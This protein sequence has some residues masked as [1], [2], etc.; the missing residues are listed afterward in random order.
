MPL[1][2]RRAPCADK[3]SQQASDPFFR[4]RKL[5]LN[6]TDGSSCDN[7]YEKRDDDDDDDEDADDDDDDDD[8][9]TRKKSTL[10][11][12]LC[13]RDA[14]TSQPIVSFVGSMD[15]CTYY[16]EIRTSAACGGIVRGPSGDGLGP[17]GVFGVM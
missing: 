6:Y 12:F 4:G 14:L 1:G 5:V 2:G 10:I 17:G 3:N 8:D 7:D 13:D 11:S 9:D 16:F 15:S